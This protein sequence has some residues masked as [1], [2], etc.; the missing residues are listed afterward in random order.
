MLP[1]DPEQFYSQSEQNCVRFHSN[2][3]HVVDRNAFDL[4]NRK[5]TILST[6]IPG[7]II[8]SVDFEFM[9]VQHLAK[10]SGSTFDEPVDKNKLFISFLIFPFKVHTTLIHFMLLHNR[11]CQSDSHRAVHRVHSFRRR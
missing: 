3:G 10:R 4:T 11:V 9:V 2:C 7:I 8:F 6:T 1:C 5:T